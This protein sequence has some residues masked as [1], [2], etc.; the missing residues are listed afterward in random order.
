LQ[1]RKLARRHKSPNS[2]RA[3]SKANQN[4]GGLG[5]RYSGLTV[6]EKSIDQNYGRD[7]F[8]QAVVEACAASVAVLDESGNILYVSR[9]WRLAAEE[10]G[11]Q[12]GRH[13]L[14]LNGLERRNGPNAE[15]SNH[16]SALAEDIQAIL[17]SRI[18][19][20]HNEYSSPSLTGSSWFVVHAA[21]LDLPGPA[22]AFRVLVNSSDITHARQA[23]ATLRDLGGRLIT[24]QEEERSR[25]ARELHDDLNQ[26]MA[27]LSVELEQIAERMPASQSALRSSIN[28]VWE[29]AQEISAEIHRVSYQLHPSKLDHLGLVAAVKSLCLE[30]SA[31][32]EIKIAFREKGCSGLLPKDVTL[33][34]FRIVQESLRNITKHSGARGASVLLV[35]TPNVI[36]LS[37]SDNGRGFDVCSVESKSGLGLI[38]M[39]ERLRSVG[40]VIS[41]HSN[42]RGTKIEVSVPVTGIDTRSAAPGVAGSVRPACCLPPLNVNA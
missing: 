7:M 40:G 14:D 26:R 17:D 16:T 22:G 13:P 41:I 3:V 12:G 29:R 31:H 35:G 9:P 5:H 8:L 42:S 38:S 37:V 1:R 10:Y 33:C 39:R 36:Q 32:Y 19:E 11:P 21:R 25:V 2:W 30:L 6:D 24:A 18:R 20:F 27:L 15:P 4:A 23:E 34:L 28:N